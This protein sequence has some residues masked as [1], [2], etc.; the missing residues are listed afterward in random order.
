MQVAAAADDADA[1]T[2]TQGQLNP[3]KMVTRLLLGSFK[4]LWASFSVTK[5]DSK[6]GPLLG[7]CPLANETVTI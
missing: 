3:H 4:Q 5:V 1:Y 2:A 6:S 7:T